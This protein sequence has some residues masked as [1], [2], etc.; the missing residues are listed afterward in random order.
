M[1]FSPAQKVCNRVEHCAQTSNWGLSMTPFSPHLK[2]VVPYVLEAPS[3]VL[4]PKCSNSS[5]LP[6]IVGIFGAGLM[7]GSLFVSM[8]VV[9]VLVLGVPWSW[10]MSKLCSV[11]TS[12]SR[13]ALRGW[14]ASRSRRAPMRSRASSGSLHPSCSASVAASGGCP[15]S[16]SRSS[17]G[18]AGFTAC[19][20]QISSSP[21]RVASSLKGG[22]T[23]ASISRSTPRTPSSSGLLNISVT[24]NSSSSNPSAYMGMMSTLPLC[25]S[26]TPAARKQEVPAYRKSTRRGSS[27][28][29]GEAAPEGEAAAA[30]EAP[31]R[32]SS[33]NSPCT[34][35]LTL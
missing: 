19:E 10:S 9:G 17:A 7:D 5:S 35:R 2:Q 8:G 20:V 1:R 4:G 21:L 6:V 28:S 30:A 25:S 34:A 33:T 14:R 27:S 31:K 11:G 26:M 16:S 23:S 32:H 18:S 3:S 13:R 29:A 15:P 24:W 22:S 12:L